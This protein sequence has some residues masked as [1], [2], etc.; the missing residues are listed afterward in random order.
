M[1]FQFQTWQG[2]L[3]NDISGNAA[4]IYALTVLPILAVAGFAID[5]ERQLTTRYQVQVSLDAA[6]LATTLRL[7]H[8]GDMEQEELNNVAQEYFDGSF[9]P[10]AHLALN[11]IDASIVGDEVLLSINGALDTTFMEII[12]QTTMPI[13]AS[14]GVVY[15]IQ[16][17]VEIT[18]VL[19]TSESMA[20]SKLTALQ[21]ASRELVDIL[22]PNEDDATAN[23]AARMSV[24]PFNDYV[25][26]DTAYKYAGWIRDTDSYTTEKES[27]ST[28]NEAREEAGCYQEEYSCTKTTGSVEQGNQEQYTGTCKRWVCPQGAEPEKTCTTKYKNYEWQ[29][30]MLSRSYPFNTT[31]A[32]YSTHPISGF[33]HTGNWCENNVGLSKELTSDHFEVDQVIGSLKAKRKTYIP[34]GLIWGLR[35]LSSQAPF[36]GAE[37]YASFAS[38]DGRKV[39][40]LMSDGANTVS[41]NS[42]GKH[43]NSDTNKANTYTEEICDEIKAQNI[44]VFTIA[45]D[46]ED[47]ETKDMLEDCATDASY[48]YDADDAEELREAFVAVGRDLAELAISR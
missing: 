8:F 26:I 39:L 23:V 18:L 34:T 46:L 12:G 14:T 9:Q 10:N 27:C 25:R 16:R 47:D 32:S 48:Y 31:D 36:E 13:G 42:S 33:Q 41:P 1:R 11:A 44:E 15:N 17:P 3:H 29:G 20:G 35:S 43:S 24:I 40:M 6:A 4:M 5:Y 38:E 30:C 21:E 19:D 45:F 7:N 22:L 2:P 28:S 37:D